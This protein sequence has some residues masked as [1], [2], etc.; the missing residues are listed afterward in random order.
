MAQDRL[1]MVRPHVRHRLSPPLVP[2]HMSCRRKPARTHTMVWGSF[3]QAARTA[4]TARQHHPALRKWIANPSP[5][6]FHGYTPVLMPC[7][8]QV[9]RR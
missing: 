6:I 1:A 7:V 5:R 9:S 2:A 8:P 4:P 3:L